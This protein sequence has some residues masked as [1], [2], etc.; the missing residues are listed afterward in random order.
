MVSNG[1]QRHRLVRGYRFGRL[2]GPDSSQ[3]QGSKWPA[4]QIKRSEAHLL[5]IQQS[6]CACLKLAALAVRHR[7]CHAMRFLLIASSKRTNRFPNSSL[8]DMSRITQLCGRWVESA[9]CTHG[10]PKLSRT[11][12]LLVLSWIQYIHI[13]IILQYALA[14][15]QELHQSALI[16]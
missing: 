3:F 4:P 2:R 8:H 5:R 9:I 13:A 6:A 14:I 10:Q 12:E 11:I 16:N 7:T 15:L 1:R